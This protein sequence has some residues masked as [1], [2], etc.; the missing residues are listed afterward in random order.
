MKKTAGRVAR[1]TRSGELKYSIALRTA[2]HHR[3]GI[4]RSLTRATIKWLRR[5]G[6]SVVRLR[7]SEDGR[8]LYET[9]GF[10]TGLETELWF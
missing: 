5:T 1:R 6:C 2:C 3:Q 7:A 9:L 10:V 8:L 4:A